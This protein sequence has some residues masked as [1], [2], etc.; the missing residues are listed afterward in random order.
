MGIHRQVPH[1]SPQLL[2]V[3]LVTSL[4]SLL[5]QRLAVR[6][7]AVSR[8]GLAEHCTTFY[9]RAPRYFKWFLMEVS[10]LSCD[11]QNVIGTTVALYILS[12]T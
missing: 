2:W 7:G 3:G 11:M 9:C 1:L 4:L 6:L 8:L 10:I 5:L 12:R